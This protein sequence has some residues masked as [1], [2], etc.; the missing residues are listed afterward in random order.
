MPRYRNHSILSAHRMMVGED[1]TH[2]YR[3]RYEMY[4]AS[5][6]GDISYVQNA[7]QHRLDEMIQHSVDV[8]HY[9]QVLSWVLST[10]PTLLER[11]DAQQRMT[12]AY[13]D[14][15]KTLTERYEDLLRIDLSKEEENRLIDDLLALPPTQRFGVVFSGLWDLALCET[16]NLN[17][18]HALYD[19]LQDVNV[20]WADVCSVQSMSVWCVLQHRAFPDLNWVSIVMDSRGIHDLLWHLIYEFPDRMIEHQCQ[21]QLPFESWFDLL[22]QFVLKTIQH[23]D[24]YFMERDIQSMLYVLVALSDGSVSIEYLYIGAH[25]IRAFRERYSISP[26]Q[27][28]FLWCH[29]FQE[30]PIGSWYYFPEMIILS[31][32]LEE[33]DDVKSVW[34]NMSSRV[35]DFLDRSCSEWIQCL[36]ISTQQ[37]LR[38]CLLDWRDGLNPDDVLK[39]ESEKDEYLE[40]LLRV[41]EYQQGMHSDEDAFQE[42][43]LYL[44]ANRSLRNVYFAR[45]TH[46][47][48]RFTRQEVSDHL[49][50]FLETLSQSPIFEQ[51]ISDHYSNPDDVLS[52]IVALRAELSKLNQLIAAAQSKTELSMLERFKAMRDSASREKTEHEI[53][54]ERVQD[55]LVD[56]ARQISTDDWLRF[57]DTKTKDLAQ[58]DLWQT[59]LIQSANA[60][61]QDQGLPVSKVRQ[62]ILVLLFRGELGHINLDNW[63]W[64]DTNVQVC[65]R[66]EEW[67]KQQ[68][69]NADTWRK[70][71]PLTHR[72]MGVY[73][74]K[75]RQSFLEEP[76]V[77]LGIHAFM[78]L[79]F[80]SA[81]SVHLYDHWNLNGQILGH[82]YPTTPSYSKQFCSTIHTHHQE[83]RTLQQEWIQDPSTRPF[84]TPSKI[85]RLLVV[86]TSVFI[87]WLQ[88]LSNDYVQ[89]T[90]LRSAIQSDG[91]YSYFARAIEKKYRMPSHLWQYLASNI[92]NFVNRLVR[93]LTESVRY[94]NLSEELSVEKDFVRVW[95]FYTRRYFLPSKPFVN[96]H[97]DQPNVVD[98]R[99]ILNSRASYL[100]YLESNDELNTQMVI[101][102]FEAV[103]SLITMFSDQ[104]RTP[105]RLARAINQLQKSQTPFILSVLLHFHQILP[106][107]RHVRVRVDDFKRWVN[108]PH[109]SILDVCVG[110]FYKAFTACKGDLKAPFN[111]EGMRLLALIQTDEDLEQAFQM[112]FLSRHFTP[113]FAMDMGALLQS[114]CENIYNQSN[115]R[116]WLNPSQLYSWL[117]AEHYFVLQDRTRRLSN[118]CSL[119][120][121]VDRVVEQD[122]FVDVEYHV[123]NFGTEAERD[124]F[125]TVHGD[126]QTMPLRSLMGLITNNPDRHLIAVLENRL[127]QWLNNDDLMPESLSVE[128]LYPIFPHLKPSLLRNISTSTD[129]SVFERIDVSE[130][131]KVFDSMQRNEPIPVYDMRQATLCALAHQ[132]P[133]TEEESRRLGVLTQNE[134][135]VCRLMGVPDAL[136]ME[137]KV[138]ALRQ[139]D[140]AISTEIF[141]DWLVRLAQSQNFEALWAVL[142]RTRSETMLRNCWGRLWLE[143]SAPGESVQHTQHTLLEWHKILDSNGDEISD[144]VREQVATLKSDLL[145]NLL[146][147][148]NIPDWLKYRLPLILPNE[149]ACMQITQQVLRWV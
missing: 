80:A 125:H 3:K 122:I 5:V 10:L 93:L 94:D 77:L 134:R 86:P 32:F 19:V 92:V 123:E 89:Y 148:S 2:T 47:L 42:S 102:H 37:Y 14:S 115:T 116:V 48:K 146:N 57:I 121:V 95:E 129:L 44:Q 74:P 40:N 139:M 56:I 135:D 52:E 68:L 128:D 118:D 133:L 73:Q 81:L 41:V 136:L 38:Q 119:N 145:A 26:N 117:V 101:D 78:R 120:W 66:T 75:P 7:V 99:R 72:G 142:V 17:L 24:S 109:T 141:G 127:Q 67:W 65:V 23:T 22:N 54:R 147:L 50:P 100:E 43:V 137:E 35:D 46:D 15:Q 33:P 29:V 9:R 138:D 140:I 131:L 82:E 130:T 25:L 62:A 16:V 28:D 126:V 31:F 88:D 112:A 143:I 84:L 63:E 144:S 79:C 124:H 90:R 97:I 45:T 30:K 8:N 58:F 76:D 132:R 114:H 18:V 20:D 107:I 49:R 103:E 87:P 1:T 108:C 106:S 61:G 98:V 39:P 13:R 6:L 27:I 70:L 111:H 34:A 55:A 83:L 51:V 85:S 53:E 91:E 36:S 4:H 149:Y 105:P 21:I 59:T 71:L 64:Y 110:S 60:I 104:T 113:D 11:L 69:S 12:E 96:S